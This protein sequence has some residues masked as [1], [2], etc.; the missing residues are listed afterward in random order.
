[1]YEDERERWLENQNS[2]RA[3]RVREV[4]AANKA[5]DADASS[6]SIRYPLRWHHLA[7]IMWC[8]DEGTEGDELASLQRFI[9]ELAQ[10]AGADANP[11][12]VAADRTVRIRMAAV[13]RGT[14]R[15]RGR[16]VRLRPEAGGRP[17]SGD[18]DDGVR[19]R[20]VPPVAP[21]SPGSARRRDGG[22]PRTNAMVISASD[23][24]LSI[25]ALLGGDVAYA[26]EWVDRGA[27]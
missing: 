11:L 1:M 27:R 10:A 21:R 4:L 16:G 8:P 2:L 9:R 22:R 6:T 23:P 19:R 25:A 20:G 24:G 17:E 18:R 5:V 12:F 13:P 14:V 7:V 15:R 3:V 26:R